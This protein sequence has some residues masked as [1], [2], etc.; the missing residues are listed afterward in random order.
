MI[1]VTI[2]AIGGTIKASS[3]TKIES[4]RTPPDTESDTLNNFAQSLDIFT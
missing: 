2:S 1:A 3:A 4:T